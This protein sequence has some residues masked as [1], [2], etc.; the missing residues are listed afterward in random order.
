MERER[1]RIAASANKA[2][3]VESLP[4]NLASAAENLHLHLEPRPVRTHSVSSDNV[5]VRQAAATVTTHR[6]QQSLD[7]VQ[8][9]KT[10]SIETGESAFI[11]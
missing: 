2:K 7:N 8:L 3:S 10:I 4:V 1:D 5:V 9:H 6:K 11:Y